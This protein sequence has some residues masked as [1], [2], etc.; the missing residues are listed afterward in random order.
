M[1]DTVSA[2]IIVRPQGRVGLKAAPDVRAS[3]SARRREGFSV[4]SYEI[5]HGHRRLTGQFGDELV[6]T[7][8]EAVLIVEGDRAERVLESS[9][10]RRT[11][12]RYEARTSASALRA[13]SSSA[14]TLP[15]SNSL[16]RRAPVGLGPGRAT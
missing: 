2:P 6:F 3:C 7:R 5:L 14:S 9:A 12:C 11:D 10:A 8:E 13:L 15:K 16:Q 1:R 4:R